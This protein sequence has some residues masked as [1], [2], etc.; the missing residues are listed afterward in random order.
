M[1]RPGGHGNPGGVGH[2]TPEVVPFQVNTTSWEKST[3][4]RSGNCRR[5]EDPDAGE[6]ELAHHV[7]DPARA[8]AFP[9]EVDAAGAEQRPQRHLDGAGVG[10]RDDG[11]EMARRHLQHLAGQARS[12]V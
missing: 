7:L 6:L 1:V 8:E 12:P 2:P 5:L 9:G 4:A 3:W 11:D 10:G